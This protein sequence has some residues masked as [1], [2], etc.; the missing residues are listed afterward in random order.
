[1]SDSLMDGDRKIQIIKNLLAILDSDAMR[2]VEQ[3]AYVH[4][5]RVDLKVGKQHSVW[6]KEARDAV[7]GGE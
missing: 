1:M 6:V 5:Y 7:V 4:G 3:M 2:G